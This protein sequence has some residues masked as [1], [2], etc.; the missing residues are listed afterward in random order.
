V[1]HPVAFLSKVLN[2]VERNYE[3][4]DTEMLAII[5]GLEEWRH[6][7]EGARHPVEIWADHKNLEYF[8]VAQKLNRRQARWSLYLSRFDFT[9][10]HKPGR[11]MGKPDALSR[12][13]DH[14]SGQGDNDNLTLLAPELF[15]IH[16]LAG[17]RLEGEERNILREVWR[18]LKVDV[19]EESVAKAARELRKDKSRGTIKSAEWSE[20]DGLLM[21]RGKIYVPKDRDLRHRIVEQHHDTRIA[22]HAGRFKTLELIARNYWWPQMSRYIGIYVKHCDLCNRTKVQR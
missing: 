14:G 7:L 5:R 19:Q 2:P 12:W 10:H 13:A 20:S 17:V 15:R 9:L 11:S 3:I 16:A 18:S 4:Q 22:G 8:R 21:F 1:W 6:Y